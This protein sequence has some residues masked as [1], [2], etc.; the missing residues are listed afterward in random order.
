MRHRGANDSALL[1]LIPY[2]QEV[3]GRTTEQA[4]KDVSQFVRSQESLDATCSDRKLPTGLLVG[5]RSSIAPSVVLDEIEKTLREDRKTTFIRLQS[6][7]CPNLKALLKVLN[8]KACSS[9]GNEDISNSVALRSRNS[10]KLLL[11]DLQILQDGCVAEAIEKVIVVLDDSEAFDGG[12]LADAIHLFKLVFGIA[13]SLELFEDRLSNTAIRCIDGQQF[14]LPAATTMFD[15]VF[16][17][18]VSSDDILPLQIGPGLC[19]SLIDRQTNHLQSVENFVRAIKYAYMCHYYG[20]AGTVFLGQAT[21]TDPPSKEHY[22]AIR[23]T[24][25][26]KTHCEKLHTDGQSDR[27][28]AIL[29]SNDA[30]HDEIVQQVD[31]SRNE[32][33]WTLGAISVLQLL[34]STFLADRDATWP[35]LYSQAM[36]GRLECTTLTWSTRMEHPMI[37]HILICIKGAP[38]PVLTHLLSDI[39]DKLMTMPPSD[40]IEISPDDFR[41]VRDELVQLE[42]GREA[43]DDDSTT[44]K[45]QGTNN[46]IRKSS[47]ITTPSRKNAAQRQPVHNTKQSKL[48]QQF[49]LHLIAYF[50]KALRPYKSF[51]LHE[52]L[53]Y[54]IKAAHRD[55]F[56]KN[57]RIA[58][59]HGLAN[60]HHYLGCACCSPDSSEDTGLKASQPPTAVLYKLYLD[61]GALINVADLWHAFNQAVGQQ[62]GEDD[63]LVMAL[64]YRGLAELKMLGMIKPSR[65][66]VDC[67]EKLAWKGL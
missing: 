62:Y 16:E 58:I 28:R 53:F 50:S 6:S 54:N 64:F 12:L 22:Q 39:E 44:S 15:S 10:A 21:T 3:I 11:Y 24:D 66:K 30:L 38:A 61:C 31:E 55:V 17:T 19:E 9:R 25:S 8:Q 47:R 4:V 56:T 36:S 14:S 59:E 60:P 65:K 51:F 20:N 7:E 1:T 45:G 46:T 23:N 34:A 42:D 13:S 63:K 27:V 49:C 48:A 33:Q 52:I 32:L 35:K 43:S 40:H 5:E 57:P 29:E 37:N 41:D 18:C 2:D 26:F 67:V